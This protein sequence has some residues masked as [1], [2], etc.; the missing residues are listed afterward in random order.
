MDIDLAL[1]W[2]EILFGLAFIQQSIEQLRRLPILCSLRIALCICLLMQV[3]QLPAL[4]GLLAIAFYFL[5]HYGGPYNGGSDRMSLLILLSLTLAHL[6]P[7][8]REVFIG[9]LA[10]QLILSYFVSGWVKI[11]KREWRRGHA[12]SDV[13]AFSVYPVSQNLRRLADNK[14]LLLLGSWLVIVFEITFPISLLHHTALYL[15]LIIATLF[16]AANAVL[17]GLNRF[18][19]AWI[20]AFPSL[21]WLQSELHPII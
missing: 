16:H 19:W 1:Y 2:T 10:L 8:Y 7:A 14:P 18:L 3:M 11:I 17:F 9:Y 15:F 12:L 4:I 6:F 20:A 13:F 5:H 21:I